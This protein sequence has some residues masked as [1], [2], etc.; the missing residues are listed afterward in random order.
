MNFLGLTQFLLMQNKHSLY[1]SAGLALMLGGF[2]GSAAAGGIFSAGNLAGAALSAPVDPLQAIESSV[3]SSLSQNLANS[4][5]SGVL[6]SQLSPTDQSFRMQQFSGALQNGAIT[7]P[8]SWTNQATGSV[9]QLNPVGSLQTNAQTQ[10]Q[11]QTLQETVT[12]PNGQT[13]NENRLA[14]QNPQTGQWTLE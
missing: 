10:Q 7:Q 4:L 1:A 8:Q 5:V 11:C 9:M 6:G 13:V 2:A 3:V 14:C 12:L